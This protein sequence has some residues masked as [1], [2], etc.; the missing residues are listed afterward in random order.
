ESVIGHGKIEF[1]DDGHKFEALKI[2]MN[3]YH[4]ED[5]KFN[6]DMMKATTVFKLV[7]SDMTGKRRN[8]IH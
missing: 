5:F 2:L 1:I 7:V 3:Q 8:N 6:T 4:A